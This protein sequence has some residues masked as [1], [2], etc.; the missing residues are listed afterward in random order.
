[1]R[2]RY[3]DCR[4]QATVVLNVFS[5]ELMF[6]KKPIFSNNLIFM[7]VLTIPSLHEFNM[8]IRTLFLCVL[9]VLNVSIS[10]FFCRNIQK[11]TEV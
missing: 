3:K 5:D 9:R 11:Y 6:S 7:H 1:M 8:I 10:H 2:E 4:F